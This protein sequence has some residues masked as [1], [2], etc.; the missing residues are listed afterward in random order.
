MPE[1]PDPHGFFDLLRR[2]REGDRDAQDALVREI[3]PVLNKE[4]G[5]QLGGKLAARARKSDLMQGA[6]V[7]VLRGLP[8]FKGTTAGEFVNWSRA[9]LA[10]FVRR[11]FRRVETSKRKTS[12]TPPREH[13][14]ATEVGPRGATPSAEAVRNEDRALLAR[15]LDLLPPD[16][17][18]A[19]R[20][21]RI[22]GL[23]HRE[24]ALRLDRSEPAMRM[25]FS[26]AMAALAV[27]LKKLDGA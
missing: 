14:A 3:Q 8:K 13:E 19:I 17:R 12:S 26:R 4:A 11:Q 20:L 10:N 27:T 6:Y 24:A 1:Q 18:E 22:E 7:D 23:S 9:I 2:A 16:Q 21:V 25:L 5:R 15:A